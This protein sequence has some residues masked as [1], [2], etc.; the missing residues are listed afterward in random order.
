MDINK[1]NLFLNKLNKILFVLFAL[2]VAAW[3]GVQFYVKQE[4]G[5]RSQNICA[6]D[7]ITA[8]LKRLNA[9]LPAPMN[10]P[11]FTLKKIGCEHHMFVYDVDMNETANDSNLTQA[12]KEWLR[13]EGHDVAKEAFCKAPQT[14]QIREYGAG[15][16]YLP[17]QRRH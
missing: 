11:G 2:S 6:D 1:L 4:Q 10:T 14:E 12:R 15:V 8:V 9:T 13:K 7:K 5:G 17:L 3:L 16:E